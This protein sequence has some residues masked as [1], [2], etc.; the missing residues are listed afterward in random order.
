MWKIQA[1]YCPAKKYA[2]PKPYIFM[3]NSKRSCSPGYMPKKHGRQWIDFYCRKKGNTMR[4]LLIEDD[5]E[6]CEAIAVHIKRDGYELDICYD[7]GDAF[8]YIS[9]FNH[10]IIMLDRM[11]P[12]MDGIKILDKLRKKGIMTPVIMI[13]AMNGINDRVDGL[14]TGADDYLVKPF[15]VEEL[16]ARIRALLRRPRKMESTDV[17]QY[18][19]I[20]FDACSYVVMHGDQR[21]SLSKREGAL[22][23]FLL[24]NRSQ[25]LT[26]EQ[27][28]NRVWGMDSFV[29]EGN[30]DNYIFLLRRRLKAI[31]TGVL[32]KTVH[33][34]GYQ[35]EYQEND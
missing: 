7:G 34:I 22:L 32:I 5:K 2:G 1:G 24:L 35:L 31:H 15:V 3:K 13:T 17:L 19:D 21:I 29:E 12:G 23:E 6:L 14:D 33:G 28:L 30:L 18:G 10:D 26:R 27:I 16:L 11:L 8:Y 9:N 25:I 20:T 4:L